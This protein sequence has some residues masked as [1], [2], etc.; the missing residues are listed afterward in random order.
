[1]CAGTPVATR[2]FPSGVAHSSSV[3]PGVKRLA[4]LSRPTPPLSR[5]QRGR[6]NLLGSK[7]RGTENNAARTILIT[8]RFNSTIKG[9]ATRY[10]RPVHTGARLSMRLCARCAVS[11]RA[12]TGRDTLA[13][14]SR[15][16]ASLGARAVRG[17]SRVRRAPGAS[18]A[19]ATASARTA[20]SHPPRAPLDTAPRPRARWPPRPSSLRRASILSRI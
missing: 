14:G 9:S 17:S 10:A 7:G 4:P 16:G 18:H 3:A 20:R 5:T 15:R 1:M 8:A 19:L 12:C 11:D 13:P 6:C 2:R